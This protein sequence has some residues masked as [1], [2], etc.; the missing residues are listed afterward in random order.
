MNSHMI[1]IG[2][3]LVAVGVL[4]MLMIGCGGAPATA[5]L[6]DFSK[7]QPNR[8]S[9]PRLGGPTYHLE[10]G[11]EL[12]VIV[13][14]EQ[15]STA[16]DQQPG[17]GALTAR[18]PTA[19]EQV[20]V[21]LKHT[22][23]QAH[24]Q[25][26]IA[27]V[28]VTQQFHNPYDSKME[29]VYVFPLPQN[30]AVNE[31]QMTVGQRKIRGII[32]ERKQAEQ[33]YYEA[34]QQGYVASL[35]TQER[36]NVF[37]QKVANIEPGHGID[38]HIRYFHTLQYDDGWYEYVFPMVVGPR[39]NPPHT[40]GG[41][42]TLARGHQG[43]S[44][45]RTEIQYLSPNERSGHDI[46]LAL[47]VEA[48]VP[49]EDIQSVNHVIE[50]TAPA[51]EQCEVRL[52]STDT[53][54]NKDFVFRYRVA[55][56]EIRTALLTHSNNEGGYFTLVAYPPFD[57]AEQPR[58]AMEM[59]FVL[60]CSGSMNGQPIR[61][62]KQAIARALEHL[63]PEDTFQIIQFSSNASRLGPVPLTATPNNIKR[64]LQYLQSLSGRGGTYM[65]EGLRAALDF[66]HDESRFR[67]VSFMTDGY[68][69][70]EDE[71]L[72]AVHKKIG[73]SRIFS[74]GVGQAPN[75]F[76]MDRMAMLG[77]GAVAY[78]GLNDDAK[79][80]MDRFAQRIRHP[81]M[82]DLSIDWGGTNVR[83]V[84]PQRLPDL[85][86]GRQIVVTGR[87]DG[88]IRDVRIQGRVG[89]EQVSFDVAAN[90]TA[91]RAKHRG[92]PAVWAR[93]KIADLMN[94]STYEHQNKLELQRSITEVALN[95]NLM[96]SYT[97]MIAVDSLTKTTGTFGT[98]VA[99]P[100]PMPEGVRYD[101]TVAN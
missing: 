55:G 84:Y 36:P 27:S 63:H 65:I 83:D 21:P 93:L 42:G 24:I 38:I 54:P 16:A 70:N 75:R 88:E 62:A 28:E 34:R 4:S 23:V 78:L 26:Y 71:V 67:L 81:A 29:A 52:A 8:S 60:D 101:T 87:F 96:S 39:F 18:L 14:P 49:I 37:T 51:P 69:G 61:Q 80:V 99:V 20:P 91:S 12:W 3:L 47:S 31:F 100:V 74:F 98:T 33:I 35:L 68:I 97:A 32:R 77:R 5:P 40:S 44:G 94:R 43:T 50:T 76:L 30:A 79:D 1:R 15:R 90:E 2:L 45:Q 89:H 13:E 56:S 95:H 82:T 58:T 41:I 6:S 19:D 92:I 72:G 17:S 25:G 10:P 53:V 85:I 66:P 48:G 11:E 7:S 22:D 46:S 64:G 57:L 59:I 73:A 86:V 9:S